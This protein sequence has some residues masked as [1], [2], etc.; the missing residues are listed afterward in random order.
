MLPNRKVSSATSAR[1]AFGA[2]VHQDREGRFL[3]REVSKKGG[4]YYTMASGSKKIIIAALIGNSLI[5]ITKFIAAFI[6]SSSAML[7]EGIHSVVDTGNDETP[8]IDF[9]AMA[10]GKIFIGRPFHLFQ[11]I[12]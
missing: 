9:L 11:P 6:T 3:F 7:S 5:A 8:E 4:S 12:K 1:G 10:E 2:A